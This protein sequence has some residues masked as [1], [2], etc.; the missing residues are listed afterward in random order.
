METWR[1]TLLNE[2]KSYINKNLNPA[3]VNKID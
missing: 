3:K 2:V 1:I